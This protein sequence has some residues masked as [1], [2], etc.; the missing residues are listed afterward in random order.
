MYASSNGGGGGGGVA[1]VTSP[2]SALASDVFDKFCN[3]VTFKSILSLYRQLCDLLRLKPTYFPL[4]YPKLKVSTSS[5]VTL[6]KFPFEGE[7]RE[8]KKKSPFSSLLVVMSPM[9]EC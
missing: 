3:A 5:S 7:K 6:F 9:M 2:D 8:K 4:F 1:R